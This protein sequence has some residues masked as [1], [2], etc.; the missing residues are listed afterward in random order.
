MQYNLNAAF[1]PLIVAEIE[2]HRPLFTFKN[3]PR[4]I[5]IQSVRL[6][7]M[8]FKDSALPI[9]KYKQKTHCFRKRTNAVND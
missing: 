4:I 1:V 2:T 8:Y 3:V 6:Y 5:F 7:I 9:K